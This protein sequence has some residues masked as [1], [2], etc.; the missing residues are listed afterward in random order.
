MT[1]TPDSGVDD[2]VGT[3]PDV[4]GLPWRELARPGSVAWRFLERMER[5]GPTPSVFANFS[6][7][8]EG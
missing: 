7:P 2:I 1:G 6:P 3:L 8:E 4:T 5:D